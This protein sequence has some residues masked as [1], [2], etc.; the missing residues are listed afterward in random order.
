MFQQYYNNIVIN[1]A[2]IFFLCFSQFKQLHKSCS[3][4]VVLL[5]DVCLCLIQQ[6]KKDS[7][8]KYYVILD[9]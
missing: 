4:L 1:Q 2:P 9:V 7:N 3:I 6:K 8:K 5:K